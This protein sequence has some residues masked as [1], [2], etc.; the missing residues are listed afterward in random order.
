M[1]TRVL[2]GLVALAAFAAATG[3]KLNQKIAIPGDGSWD[4]LTVDG[5]ARRVYV[6]H[7]TE[8]NVLDADTGKL[9]G[10]LTGT[11]GVH[12]IALAREF[13]RGFISSGQ[14]N[15][16]AVFD[17]KTQ[18]IVS[19][20]TAGKKPD[21]IIYDRATKRVIVN[22]GGSAS[23]TILNAADAKPEGDIEL[24]GQPEFAAVDG[25]GKV[26]INLED[27][28]E[29]VR[30][31][32]VQRKVEARW[33]LKPCEAPSAMAMDRA[34]RR[35]FIGCHNRMMAVVNA[36]AGAVVQ[37]LPIGERVDAAAFDRDAKLVFFSCGDGTVSVFHEDTPDRLTSVE[38][39]TTEPGAKTLA[40]D[41]KTH[42][43][44][45]S[46]AKREGKTIQP[47]TFHVLVYGR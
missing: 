44:F 39:L 14:T 1:R 47:G 12:G 30:I 40:L 3:Y 32:P 46:V 26:F 28:N 29:T 19:R 11:L 41:S 10:T 5:S 21:A 8:V 4:Y 9:A 36:D 13:N 45:L 16:V 2:M 7:G 20:V 24:G 27:K 43:L 25:K 18:E 6:S 22:N 34:A 37:T 35:L 31:D 42:N 15:D 33:A 17:L 38:T 23:S